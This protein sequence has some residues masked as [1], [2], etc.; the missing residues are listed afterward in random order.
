MAEKNILAFFKSTEEAKNVA[1]QMKKLGVTDLQIDRFSN[2]PLG[3]ADQ[4]TNPVNGSTSSQAQL[5]L[6]AGGGKDT[7]ILVSADVS[8]SGMSDGGQDSITGRDVLI[9]A[10][11]DEAVFDQSIQLIKDAGGLV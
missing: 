5:T 10:I 11:V 1:H 2:Y 6:G 8:A 9:A 7:G 3:S 4:L